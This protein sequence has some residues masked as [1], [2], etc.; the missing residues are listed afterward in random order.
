M[1]WD[2]D[3][4][5]IIT[6]NEFYEALMTLPQLTSDEAAQQLVRSMDKTDMES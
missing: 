5:G 3:Q 1:D 6:T 4:D 2:T